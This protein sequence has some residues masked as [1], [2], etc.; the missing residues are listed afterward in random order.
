MVNRK[1]K[2]NIPICEKNADS[3]GFKEKPYLDY[4]EV[5]NC[6]CPILHNQ[7]NLGNKIFHN[8]LVYGNKNIENFQLMK[9]RLAT[10]YCWMIQP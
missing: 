8:L 6:I 3:L 1:S 4:A 5:D 9:I 10:F 2:N 7:I